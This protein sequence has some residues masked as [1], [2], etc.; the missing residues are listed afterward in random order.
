MRTKVNNEDV[1][2]NNYL[3]SLDK[4]KLNIDIIHQYLS[5]ESYWAKGISRKTV[6]AS[7]QNSICLGIYKYD[8]EFIGFGRMI[9]DKATFAYLA[10]IFILKNYR[11]QSLSKEMVAYFCRLADGL[12]LR[13]FMLATADAH[14]L[15]R[16]YGFEEIS[17]PKI[18]MSRRE[19]KSL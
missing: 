2:F 1:Y 9:T 17:N 6:E 14:E 15:Y 11:G 13:R 4:S 5:V 3:F 18:I 7:I 19:H 16:K 10:D 8:D 12:G